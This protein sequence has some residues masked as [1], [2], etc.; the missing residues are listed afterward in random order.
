MNSSPATVIC[1]VQKIVT[2]CSKTYPVNL[3]PRCQAERQRANLEAP[4]RLSS[5]I[6][7]VSCLE[8]F[9][10]FPITNSHPVQ[11]YWDDRTDSIFPWIVKELSSENCPFHVAFSDGVCL[12][13]KMFEVCLVYVDAVRPLYLFGAFPDTGVANLFV[14]GEWTLVFACCIV[15]PCFAHSSQTLGTNA[16]REQ[17][18]KL[19]ESLPGSSSLWT[20]HPGQNVNTYELIVG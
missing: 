7:C 9:L 6:M 17:I 14:P 15:S 18:D 4:S 20:A 10:Q 3:Q 5:A 11:E 12:G 19:H 2:P 1:W 13:F 8:V 16:L